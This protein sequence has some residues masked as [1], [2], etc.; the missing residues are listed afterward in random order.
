MNNKHLQWKQFGSVTSAMHGNLEI[1]HQSSNCDLA[2]KSGCPKVLYTES[3]C[4]ILDM[5][6]IL[7]AYSILIYVIIAT[8]AVRCTGKFIFLLLCAAE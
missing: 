6:A 4:E 3:Q 2:D 1:I 7:V 5:I 8:R